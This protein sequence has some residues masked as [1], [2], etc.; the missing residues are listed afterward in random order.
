MLLLFNSRN[1]MI[2]PKRWSTLNENRVPEV[3]IC[4]YIFQRAF[5]TTSKVMFM[6]TFNVPNPTRFDNFFSKSVDLVIAKNIRYNVYGDKMRISFQS[7]L[8]SV[9][10]FKSL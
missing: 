1:I 8:K 6:Y 3:F 2:G 5:K 9:R 7:N 10:I 4:V